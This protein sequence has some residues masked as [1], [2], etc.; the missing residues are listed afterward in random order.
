MSA[1]AELKRVKEWAW[2]RGFAN[3]I[4]RKPGMVVHET[5]VDQR[6]AVVGAGGRHVGCHAV[7]R[8]ASWLA[9]VKRRWWL[10][11]VGW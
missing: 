10:I 1:N 7:Y 3:C 11:T 5:L 6:L 4:K 9:S 2:M 8:S